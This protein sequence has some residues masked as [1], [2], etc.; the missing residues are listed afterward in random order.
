M[1]A[2]ETAAAPRGLF[3]GIR[4]RG[5]GTL[6]VTELK[7]WLREPTGVFFALVFPSLLLLGLGLAIPDF[8]KPMTDAPPP[9]NEALL[10][11]SPAPS[12]SPQ[13]TPL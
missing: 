2:V 10:K 3:R 11:P 9:W 4:A 13:T 5:F 1:T 12:P 6:F 7:V 8:S